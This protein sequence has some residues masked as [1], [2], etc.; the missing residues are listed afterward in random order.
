MAQ[1]PSP[2]FWLLPTREKEYNQKT[3]QTRENSDANEMV[4]G[5]LDADIRL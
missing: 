4:G 5:V 2:H 1:V 3:F